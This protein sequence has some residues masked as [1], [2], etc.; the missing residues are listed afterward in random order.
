MNPAEAIALL[1]KEKVDQILQD[2]S[3][4]VDMIL[5]GDHPTL[6]MN[7]G[8]KEEEKVEETIH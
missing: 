8:A 7:N 5:R 4:L 6:K 1:G 2:S 3:D